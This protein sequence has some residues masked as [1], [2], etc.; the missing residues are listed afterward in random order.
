MGHAA[1]GVIATRQGSGP[2]VTAYL[3]SLAAF[4]AA[5]TALVVG[6]ANGGGPADATSQKRRQRLRAA[7]K[8]NGS[9]QTL[10]ARRFKWTHR[11]NDNRPRSAR[12]SAILDR[13][14]LLSGPGRRRSRSWRTQTLVHWI[15]ARDPSVDPDPRT[16]HPPPIGCPNQL[17]APGFLPDCGGVLATAR[18]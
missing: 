9:S 11:R 4:L 14:A 1:Q 10:L 17:L 16:R 8:S 18:E 5:T 12:T 7:K 2:D 6:S 15:G 13:G 3:I